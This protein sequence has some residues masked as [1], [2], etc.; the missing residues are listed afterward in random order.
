MSEIYYGFPNNLMD[1]QERVTYLRERASKLQNAA[2]QTN[3][4]AILELAKLYSSLAGCMNLL[5][6]QLPYK[7][8]DR[9]RLVIAP[10]CEGGWASSKHFLVVGAIGTIKSVYVD[11]LMRDWSV[12]VEFDDESWIPSMT[13]DGRT[14]GVPVLVD[15]NSRHIYGFAPRYI[16]KV[17]EKQVHFECPCCP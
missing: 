6:Q 16:E 11:Y 9:V 15:P 12:Y 3:E 4:S 7:V 8:G 13:Y 2:E 5:S 1:V 17:P 10:K 14:A